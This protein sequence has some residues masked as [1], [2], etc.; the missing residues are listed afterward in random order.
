MVFN[1]SRKFALD[2][3]FDVCYCTQT[4]IIFPD[5]CPVLER[6]MPIP[7]L[8]LRTLFLLAFAV[9]C[10]AEVG[11]QSSPWKPGETLFPPSSPSSTIPP[12]G[13]GSY[14]LNNA[15]QGAPSSTGSYPPSSTGSGDVSPFAPNR[16]YGD[17]A[18]EGEKSKESGTALQP[19]QPNLKAEAD[20][21]PKEDWT[22]AS[23]SKAE[24]A[25]AGSVAAGSAQ[26]VAKTGDEIEIPVSAFR[27][28]TG[29]HTDGTLASKAAGAGTVTQTS[30]I[31]PFQP[32]AE[33]SEEEESE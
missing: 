27:T 30:Y 24:I 25:N 6:Q 26:P 32:D 12:P 21:V 16:P 31:A 17:N 10:I 8:F 33:E 7:A 28:G 18:N 11:C 23:H 29:L 5:F 15:P 2:V 20:S 14:T 9:G 1:A 22:V 3:K 4:S 13:T 19:F